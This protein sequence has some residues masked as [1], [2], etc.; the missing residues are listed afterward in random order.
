MK[1][2]IEFLI[3]SHGK[4]F[5]KSKETLSR[6]HTH[7]KKNQKYAKIQ[8]NKIFDKLPDGFNNEELN[9][10]LGDIAAYCGDTQK[11]GHIAKIALLQADNEYDNIILELN[12][13]DT[14]K[15]YFVYSLWGNSSMYLIPM[16]EN[17]N[18]INKF[19]SDAKIIVYY[20][21]SLPGKY[22]EF[23]EKND[24]ILIKEPKT[25]RLTGTFWRFYAIDDI[26]DG[27]L[28][29]RDA[30]SIITRRELILMN[31]I[32]KINKDYLIRDSQRHA[33]LILAGLFGIKSR[34]KT[35]IIR[36]LIQSYPNK[37]IRT[38]DQ[39]FLRDYFWHWFKRNAVHAD[40]YYEN[41]IPGCHYINPNKINPIQ[42]Q[43]LHIGSKITLGGGNVKNWLPNRY[44]ALNL[45][46]KEEL[47]NLVNEMTF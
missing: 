34:P 11:L 19:C 29:F 12:T 7:S 21:E 39:R 8:L 3:T 47:Q 45:K 35:K 26:E 22:I 25:L 10:Y 17:I 15:E 36:E 33:W 27:W 44:D 23:L 37:E 42:H 13:K 6:L 24:V 16:I 28:H 4:E 32:K 40:S 1:K 18:Q 20:D 2:D 41:L 46:Y 31:E 30:D 14:N 9:Q 38:Y 43:A 5:L